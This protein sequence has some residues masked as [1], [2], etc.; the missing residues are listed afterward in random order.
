MSK[1]E[2]IEGNGKI[3]NT[4]PTPFVCVMDA[5][6]YASLQGGRE[7]GKAAVGSEWPLTDGRQLSILRRVHA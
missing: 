2:D 5:S 3:G 1:R 6:N 7:G 4:G